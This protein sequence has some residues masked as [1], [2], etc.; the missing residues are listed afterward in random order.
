MNTQQ[1]LIDTLSA[2]YRA[3]GAPDSVLLGL[4]GGADSLALLRL[5]LML[6]EQE[7][8][9]LFCVHVNHHLREESDAEAKWLSSL[10]A[11][12]SVPLLVLD[13][14][15]P[16]GASPEAQARQ[17]RYQAFDQAMAF[18]KAQVLAL[19]HHA[20]DQA[21]TMLMRLMRGT[22]ATGLAAMRELSGVLWRP[23]LNASKA[24]L[25][26]LL[27][28]LNQNWLEDS[29]NQD[30]KFFRNAIR[31]Y[32][33]PELEALSPGATLRMAQTAGLLGDEEDAWRMFED[34][35]LSRH[36]SL[37]PPLVFLKREP[38]LKEPLAFQRRLARRLCAIY[39][40][41]LDKVQTDA[42]CALP[43]AGIAATMN[44]PGGT[45]A[46]ATRQHLHILPVSREGLPYPPL[47]Q[48]KKVETPLG[49]GDGKYCQTFDQDQLVGA[50]LRFPG[51]KDRITP[52]GMKGS[53]SLS[54]YLGDRKV[55]LPFRRWWPVLARE[56]E[57]LWVIGLGA[58]QAAAVTE[59]T[60][61]RIQYVFEGGLPGGFLLF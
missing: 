6:K 38:F 48:L 45:H 33:C 4:S 8:F 41:A 30:D 9:D 29:S 40:L 47:G 21:E 25:E 22:G 43:N 1:A 39:G 60:Q 61:N 7:G 24:Q 50:I 59:K 52:L 19:A 34:R 5:L 16:K 14:Q 31:H 51:P 13:V 55:D 2:S 54:K 44:L 32:I 57:V 10:M 28:A 56:D 35:W 15:V 46:Q 11:R 58:S 53:M 27:K 18:Y 20:D 26:A 36:A 49:L 3:I 42:L 37:S 17:V 12:L 23:L